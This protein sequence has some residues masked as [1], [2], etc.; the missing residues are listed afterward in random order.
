MNGVETKSKSYMI[1]NAKAPY[2]IDPASNH[3]K[4]FFNTN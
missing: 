2:Y 4:F 1:Q 3:G